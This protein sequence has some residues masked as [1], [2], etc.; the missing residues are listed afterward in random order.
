MLATFGTAKQDMCVLC[1][2]VALVSVVLRHTVI[3]AIIRNN[4]EK[5]EEEEE[6][7]VGIRLIVFIFECRL[8]FSVLYF[9]Y[10]GF[11]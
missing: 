11:P 8:F 6:V 7:F 9:P 10:F 4:K 1:V 3:V 5:E 2:N